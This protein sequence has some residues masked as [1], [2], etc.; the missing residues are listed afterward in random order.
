MAP[1]PACAPRSRAPK[2][3]YRADLHRNYIGAIERG[4]IN[5]TFRVLLKLT[6]GLSM[7]LSEIVAMYERHREAL[8]LAQPMSRPRPRG[9]A[10]TDDR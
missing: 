8:E 7:P 3:G 4:E 1:P 2:L 9:P 5:P 6:R 10:R